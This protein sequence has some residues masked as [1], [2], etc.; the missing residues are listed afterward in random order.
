MLWAK[1]YYPVTWILFVLQWNRCRKAAFSEPESL[2]DWCMLKIIFW[3]SRLCSGS[4][5]APSFVLGPEKKK[6]KTKKEKE[7]KMDPIPK[8]DKL[9]RSLPV[10]Q[11][12]AVNQIKQHYQIHTERL[13]I[14]QASLCAGDGYMSHGRSAS[15]KHAQEFWKEVHLKCCSYQWGQMKH[16]PPSYVAQMFFIWKPNRL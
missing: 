14:N 8:V 15:S 6:R 3:A 7:K 4:H 5:P 2:L 9:K 16:V 13:E 12:S 10:R 1:I 11:D